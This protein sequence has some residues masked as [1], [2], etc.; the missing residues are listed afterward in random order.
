MIPFDC[1]SPSAVGLDPATVRKFSEAQLEF[2]RLA[3]RLG[4]VGSDQAVLEYKRRAAQ[5]EQHFLDGNAPAPIASEADV[6]REFELL[7][8]RI[9]AERWKV[10]DPLRPCLKLIGDQLAVELDRFAT[11]AQSGYDAILATWNISISDP[12]TTQ[13]IHISDGREVSGPAPASPTSP[14][15]ASCRGHARNLRGDEFGTPPLLDFIFRTWGSGTA[16][17]PAELLLQVTG[18]PLDELTRSRQATTPQTRSPLA[19]SLAALKT[20]IPSTP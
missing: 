4:L 2:E 1:I 20:L 6:R 3:T 5:A 17:A 18:W 13:V 15:A 14:I 7:S 16:P 9:N 11:E 8:T 10:V 12:R 19:R